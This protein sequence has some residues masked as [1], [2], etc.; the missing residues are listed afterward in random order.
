MSTHGPDWWQAV[1]PFLDQVLGMTEEVRAE[2]LSSL[3]EQNPDL[4]TQLEALLHEHRAL[5]Q[6]RFLDQ[7]PAVP[8]P[9]QS[10]LAGQ[11]IG[12]YTLLSPI[13]EGGMGSVW[14]A[15]RSDGRF[16]RRAAV[17]LLK[18]ALMGRGGERFKREGT[19][20][21]RLAHPHIAQLLDAGVS[22]EGQP[23]LILEYV[24]GED[25]VGYCDHRRLDVESRL[26]LFLDVLAAVAHAHANL[27]VHRDLKPS[28]VL[29][30][31][32]GQV[33][34][35]DFGIAKLLEDEGQTGVAALL[36]RE[37]GGALTPQYAAPEQVTN[38]PMT[39]ATDIYG[40]GVLLY[41]LLTGEH[42]AGPSSLSTSDLVKSIVDIEPRRMSEAVAHSGN[43]AERYFVNTARRVT[44]DKLCRLLRGDL[45]TVVAKALKKNPKERYAS[46]TAF[47][48]DLRRYLG[49]EPIGARPD[50]LVYRAAKFVRRN[51]ATAALA[52]LAFVVTV[53]GIVATIIQA[54]SVRVERD[55]A[56][57]QLARAEAVNNLN[58]FLLSDAAPSG[59]PLTV[60]DLLARAEHIVKRQRGGDEAVRAELLVSIGYQYHILGDNSKARDL[61]TQAYQLSRGLTD[62]PVRARAGCALAV[63]LAYGGEMQRAETFYHDGIS[64]VSNNPLFVP[65]RIFCLLRGGEVASRRG[66][67]QDSLARVQE[68]QRLLRQS[69]VHPDSLEL[70]TLIDLGQAYRIA[71]ENQ[72]AITALKQAAALLT[73]LGRDDTKTAVWAFHAWAVTLLQLGRPREAE[74]LFRRALDISRAEPT[75][76]SVSPILLRDYARDLRYLGR[77]DEAAPYAEDAY[78]TALKQGSPTVVD[79]TLLERSRIYREQGNLSRAQAMVLEAEERMRHDLP[80]GHYSFAMLKEERALLAEA[81][82]DLPMA[83]NHINRA[84]SFLD[85]AIKAG[86]RGSSLIPVFLVSRSTIELRLHQAGEAA[87]DANR[88]VTLFQ[89][90]TEPAAFSCDVGR[91]YLALGRALLAQGKQKE[92]YVAFR[93][94]VD[95]LQNALGPDHP[96]ARA[97]RQLAGL[98]PI[99]P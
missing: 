70:V 80:A 76:A 16:E 11:T 56:M 31:S 1:S 39:T 64:E 35:L 6:E 45:D 37:F 44:R 90:A 66:S 14:L 91:A 75:D 33:K 49:H 65:D 97:A 77:L 19:I 51:R 48:D 58:S 57:R 32:E 30:T 7:E 60:L 47:A 74:P 61:L 53:A 22:A 96:D 69:P 4:A 5:V 86:Q 15:G 20:L 13:G 92:A 36:T 18:L 55:F 93:S 89:H 27:I 12:A 78:S 52:S 25:I 8:L 68:A 79:I 83:M 3:R 62:R 54:R 59:K 84:I 21:A 72:E 23:Y 50:T 17:K 9:A 42:P 85:T 82:G 67:S 87:T 46:A 71:G 43:D 95:Q 99:T 28:N 2:W 88:A 41:V 26:R 10:S 94:A 73:T 34:L 98:Q 24:E 29:V 40:L 81:R 63:A 38:G